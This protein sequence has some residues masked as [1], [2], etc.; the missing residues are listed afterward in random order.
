MIAARRLVVP[1]LLAL[2]LPLSGCA[3]FSEDGPGTRTADGRPAVVAAFYPLQFL[4]ERVGGDLV[5]VTGLTKPG[6]E[7]HDMTLTP[8]QSAEVI[9]ADLVVFEKGLQ[10]S[11]DDAVEQRSAEAATYDVVPTAKLQDVGHD[12]HDHGGEDSH[13]GHEGH[14]HA[15][16][17]LG[18]LDPHFWVDPARMA[19]VA[20]ELADRLADV[21]PDHADAYRANAS[22]LRGELERLDSDFSSTLATCSRDTIVVSHDAF[23]YWSRYGLEIEPIAGLSPD[24]EPTP[25][26]LA[27]LQDLIR[28]DGVTTVFGETLVSPKLSETL[29]KDAGVTTAVLD[30]V[31]GLASDSAGADYLSIMRSNL[32]ALKKANGCQ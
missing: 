20:D 28:T 18:D 9:D 17:E 30:P 29:A 13:E 24:A 10:A 16:G 15:E 21:D 14:D 27:R 12:G 3:A 11:V 4:A 5:D 2:A 25:A 19:D 22:S 1:G 8:A 32:A 7:P 31:E 6:G 23:G 26:D